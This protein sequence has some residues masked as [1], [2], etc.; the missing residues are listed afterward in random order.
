MRQV[1]PAPMPAPVVDQASVPAP[2]TAVSVLLVAHKPLL[3]E[4]LGTGAMTSPV[5]R[6]RVRAQP[7]MGT[8]LPLVTSICRLVVAPVRMLA[9]D[10][11]MLT[12]GGTL[13]GLTV[14]DPEAD[15]VFTPSDEVICPGVRL[16]L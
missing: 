6:L 14:N 12:V 2:A 9:A 5:G 4:A 3:A 16:T 1:S 15:S 11:P 7:A 8:A 13:G 10:N